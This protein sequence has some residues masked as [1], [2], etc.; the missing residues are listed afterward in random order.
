M[1]AGVGG[2]KKYMESRPDTIT[3][4]AH[5][6]SAEKISE[7]GLNMNQRRAKNL[8]KIATDYLRKEL[9]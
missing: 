1:I 3:R 7:N 2:F 8:K 9:S 6:D 4:P 5:R